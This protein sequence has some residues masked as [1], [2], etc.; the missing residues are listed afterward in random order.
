MVFKAGDTHTIRGIKCDFARIE[1]SQLD[2]YLAL[3]YIQNEKDLIESVE[4]KTIP[5]KEEAD[6]NNTGKLSSGEVRA[7]AEKAGIED[8]AKKRISTLKKELGYDD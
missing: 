8:F 7:A 4:E 2:E 1:L 5:T 6:T 3:G